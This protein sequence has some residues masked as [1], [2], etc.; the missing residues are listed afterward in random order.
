[1][2]A[3]LL[4]LAWTIVLISIAGLSA[5]TATIESGPARPHA[6]TMERA[7]VCG[8]RGSQNRTFQNACLARSQG[9]RV[10]HAGHCQGRS[11]ACTREFRPVCARRGNRSRT[12]ENSC[13]ARTAGFT[14][15][16]RGECLRTRPPSSAHIA[17]P[18][19]EAPVCAARGDRIRSFANECMARADGYRV[20]RQGTCR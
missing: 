10:L 13:L 15:I 17:C 5:C 2:G 6:C 14:V 18:M 20:V 7:P 8:Q 11:M 4:L 3:K 16:H 12:F 9:F 1:M 19:I